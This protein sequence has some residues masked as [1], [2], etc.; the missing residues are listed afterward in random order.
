M[1]RSKVKLDLVLDTVRALGVTRQ[2]AERWAEAWQVVFGRGRSGVNVEK[3]LPVDLTEFTGRDRELAHI[4]DLGGNVGPD[5]VV[6]ALEGMAGVGKTSLAVRAAAQLRDQVRSGGLELY[7]DLRGFSSDELPPADPEAVLTGLVRA[8]GY[9]GELPRDLAHRVR[10]Y[11]NLLAEKARVLLLDNVGDEDQVRHL[12]PRDAPVLVLITSRVRLPGLPSSVERMAV[13]VLDDADS[14]AL[15][16]DISRVEPTG[17]DPAEL[18]LIA[19]KCGHLPQALAAIAGHIR[20]R[21]EWALADHRRALEDLVLHGDTGGALSLSYKRLAEPHRRVLRLLAICPARDITA[22]TAAVLADVD[23]ASALASLRELERAHLLQPKAPGRYGLHDLVRAHARRMAA[24]DEPPTGRD[25]ALTRWLD[26][27]QATAWAAT[28]QFGPDQR[29]R[30]PEPLLPVPHCADAESAGRWLTAERPNL[31]AAVEWA[32]EHGQPERA[33]RLANTVSRYLR[34][35]GY[36]DD[37]L[38]VHV[39]ELSAARRGTDR[40]AEGTAHLNLGVV[41]ER[42]GSFERARHHYEEASTIAHR[43][44][45]E[46]MYALALIRTGSSLS[47]SGRADE[48]GEL[49]AAGADLARR[50]GDR[51][52]EAS[53]ENSLGMLAHQLGRYQDALVHY[54]RAHALSTALGNRANAA[55]VGSNI[56]IISQQLG[57][58][59]TALAHFEEALAVS[60]D[61][62]DVA[63]TTAALLNLGSL[64][65]LMGRYREATAHSERALKLAVG[66]KDRDGEAR[67]LGDIG[68]IER[69]SGDPTAARRSHQAALDIAMAL[70]DL[71]L[72]T[73][74]LNDLGETLVASGDHLEAD[75]TF[76]RSLEL[77]DTTGNPFEN[78]RALTGLS[79]AAKMRGH[80]D[81][82]RD[83]WHQALA[84]YTR[85]GVPEAARLRDGAGS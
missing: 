18:R 74:A 35:A 68:T 37:W 16:T 51:E 5:G 59:P 50:L 41:H 1:K 22:D 23:H 6:I 34:D 64:L 54:N 52:A 30:L 72:L 14:L 12:L 48:A 28:W 77:T 8:L 58:Y 15:I 63:G 57:D 45:D 42:W 78:A 56:G 21:P 38:F 29:A 81:T 76:S 13:E 25:E 17:A 82:A 65:P 20:D 69:L 73:E 71:D 44:G 3:R 4:V 49:L 55:K 9:K 26:D 2:H 47:E 84:I 67:A 39:Q 60:S 32:A 33:A 75:R 31:V 19:E 11:R 43:I 27:L 40:K 66:V 24:V 61:P 36:Y 70:D 10:I 53:A 46:A 79:A 62:I 7:T 85:L 80:D 83:L